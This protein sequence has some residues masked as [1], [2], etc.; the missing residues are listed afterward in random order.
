MSTDALAKFA[1]NVTEWRKLI[2]TVDGE[3]RL[4]MFAD[5]A[6]EIAGYINEGVEKTTAVDAIADI[7]NAHAGL[8]DADTVQMIIADAFREAEL[9]IGNFEEAPPQQAYTN[10]K[11]K[12]KPKAQILSKRAFIG[13]FVPPDYLIAG[14]LQ[15]RFIYALTGQTGHAKTAVALLIARLV[16]CKLNALFGHRGV[17][18]GRVIYFVGENPDDV[19]MRV[20]GMDSRRDDEP[21]KDDISF[22]PGGGLKINE[23]TGVLEADLRVHGEAAL[24]IVDT[25]AAYFLGNDEMSNTQM[26]AHAR[27][28]RALTL[29]PG[30]PCVLVLCH[31][32]KHVSDQAQLLP[33]GGSAFLAEVDG[34]LTLWRTSNEL[35][36][37]HW[38]GKFRGPDFPPMSFRL[39][40]IKDAIHDADGRAIA[41]V[42]AV[43]ITQQEQE[44]VEKRD[45][46]EQDA[47]LRQM[48]VTPDQS[49]SDIARGL[50]WEL[51]NGDANKV[52][53]S[54]I[55]TGLAA[56]QQRRLVVQVRKKW[57]LTEAGKKHARELALRALNRKEP[58]G[59]EALHF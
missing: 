22:I 31:P 44:K 32:I 17:K 15:R 54:R 4:T 36:E 35:I 12:G 24:I 13:G 37:M 28:L 10:G 57:N 55:L 8:A 58:D 46:N 39:E 41:T 56:G 50:G 34:N 47:V 7:A 29:L 53:V 18:K 9:H 21:D 59:Q 42:E 11:D 26:G 52:K 1:S 20:I 14:I 27:M 23:I 6:N 25:S 19:R 43:A 45:D 38:Q 2:A 33:R 3:A 5:A 30:G 49:L 40:P 16:S 51:E 48:L